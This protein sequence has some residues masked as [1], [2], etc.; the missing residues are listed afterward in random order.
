MAEGQGGGAARKCG[1]CLQTFQSEE[2]LAA[3]MEHSH[4]NIEI[5]I[6]EGEGTWSVVLTWATGLTTHLFLGEVDGETWTMERYVSE[7]DRF[8]DDDYRGSQLIGFPNASRPEHEIY[9]GRENLLKNLQ[10]VH[11]IFS[12]SPQ[13]QRKM[14]GHRIAVA[15]GPL[16]FPVHGPGKR[17]RN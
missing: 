17:G 6:P 10:H 12:Q 15:T 13:A 9:F 7:L 1:L 14:G 5:E 3:H 8:L 16:P 4:S 2:M 11:L